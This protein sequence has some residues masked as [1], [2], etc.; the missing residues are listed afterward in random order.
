M[1][2][3]HASRTA[4]GEAAFFLPYLQRGMRLLD[5]GCGPG[6]I[7]MDLAE[8]VAPGDVVGLDIDA[9]RVDR[10]QALAQERGLTN[11][12]IQRADINDLPF[13]SE[14]FDAVF[15]H[16]VFMHMRDP[17]RA[18]AEAFRVLKRGGCFGG[19]DDDNGGWL[20]SPPEM[21]TVMACFRLMQQFLSVNGSNYA[22][23]RQLASVV[24]G[25]GFSD[26]LPT[27]SYRMVNTAEGRAG[28]VRISERLW[29]DPQAV[30][31]AEQQ[32]YDLAGRAPQALAELRAWAADPAAFVAQSEC[33]VVAWKP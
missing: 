3:W 12:T 15:E 26:V 9:D 20:W 6:T 32:G 7:T 19:C 33:Q 16:A 1:D 10:A 21:A 22:F 31:F 24:R 13:S 2:T 30:A 14:S 23:G 18:A 4:V 29:A 28:S 17:A 25:A 5:L 11:V 8:I 27:A